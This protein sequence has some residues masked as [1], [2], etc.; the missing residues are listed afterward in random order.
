[1][2]G[3]SRQCY[4]WEGCNRDVYAIMDFESDSSIVLLFCAAT[5]FSCHTSA[6]DTNRCVAVERYRGFRLS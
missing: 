3:R 4:I 5:E 6:K 1:M 2:E